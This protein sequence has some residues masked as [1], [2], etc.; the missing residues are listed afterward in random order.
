MKII[1]IAKGSDPRCLGGIETFE[2]ILGKAFEDDIKFY[3][4]NT[5]REYIF[6]CKNIINI[7]ET[8]SL[9]EKVLLKILGKTRYTSL[10]IKKEN[11]DVVIINK[12]KDLKMLKGGKF[13]KILVQHNSLECYRNDVFKIL[14]IIKSIQKELDYYVFLSDKSKEIFLDFLKLDKSK[15]ITI[16]HSCEIELLDKVKLKNRK[17]IIIS[18]I[19]NK[20]KRI[21]L[22]IKAMKKLPEFTLNIYGTGPDEKMLKQMV[23]DE[24]LQERVFFRG[25]TNKVKEKLDE[26]SIFIMTSDYEGYGITNIEAMMRGL[27]IILRNTFESAPDI[28]KDNGILLEKEWNED[29]FVE[30]VYKVYENYDYYSKNT[31][32][33]GKRHTFETIKNEWIE[34][35][36]NIKNSID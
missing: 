21:D 4:Y 11:P 2:R 1:C 24:K 15:G 17:L 34:F 25:A 14:R 5:D 13:L 27:P 29:K 9:I 36:N 10:K 6:D 28:V 18:R 31:I 16:R 26:A 19:D 22:A 30:A 23:I 32:E 35:M 12:P 20:A 7:Q 33:M 3:V 8:N